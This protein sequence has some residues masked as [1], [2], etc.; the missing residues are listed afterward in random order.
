M[1]KIQHILRNSFIIKLFFIL[2]GV[3]LIQV[4]SPF[5]IPTD[6][7][8]D[9]IQTNI[10]LVVSNE[11]ENESGI[12]ELNTAPKQLLEVTHNYFDFVTI[13]KLSLFHY[14]TYILNQLK[15][16]EHISTPNFQLIFILQ[17]NNIWHQS[18]DKDPVL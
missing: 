15:S 17:K 8:N 6:Y 2:I 10:E 5:E 18:S 13:Y 14:R 11:P 12:F 3:Y 1:I 9:P 16:L 7:C 4:R